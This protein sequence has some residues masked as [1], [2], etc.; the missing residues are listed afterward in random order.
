MK[1]ETSTIFLQ[2]ISQIDFAMLDPERLIPVGGSYQLNAFVK[3]SIDYLEQVV[4]DFSTIKKKIKEFVDDKNKGFDHKFWIPINSLKDNKIVIDENYDS[5]SIKIETPNFITI[6]PHNAVRSYEDRIIESYLHGLLSKEYPNSNI[7]VSI[8]FSSLPTIPSMIQGTEIEFNYIHGL[9]NST[10]WGCQNISH[11]HQS[12]LSFVDKH[13]FGVK[14][15]Y[16][17]K[18]KIENFIQDA[19]FIWKENIVAK[20]SGGGIKI[21][22]ETERGHFEAIY[23]GDKNNIIILDTETTVE[24]LAKWFVNKFKD[25]ISN[26]EISGIWFS[27]GLTKGAFQEF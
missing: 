18:S 5:E 4:I 6:V 3:G 12:W 1:T 22:Y 21:E 23:K 2:N 25:E 8:W 16:I 27:E 13:N 9:K 26:K 10:S 15:D 11:G 17:L 14:I 7:Q 19:V 24:N 20:L